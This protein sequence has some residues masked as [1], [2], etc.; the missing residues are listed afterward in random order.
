MDIDPTVYVICD[1]DA[2]NPS[3]RTLEALLAAGVLRLATPEETVLI[4]RDEPSQTMRDELD[5]LIARKAMLEPS[6]VFELDA[7]PM[8]HASVRDRSD[9][10]PRWAGK[11]PWWQR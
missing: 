11:K 3:L 5:K 7:P 10:R 1:A 8:A 9:D 6:K 4:A 2:W